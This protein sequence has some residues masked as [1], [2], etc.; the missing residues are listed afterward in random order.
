MPSSAG[1]AAP[2]YCWSGVRADEPEVQLVS[3]IHW[4]VPDDFWVLQRRS[5]CPRT[6][7][8]KIDGE[9]ATKGRRGDRFAAQYQRQAIESMKLHHRY[10]FT[11]PVALDLLFISRAKNPPAIYSAAKY[12]LDL[13][14]DVLPVNAEPRRRHVIYRDDRQVRFLYA[15][16]HQRWEP[17]TASE[18]GCTYI[19]ARPARDAIADLCAAYELSVAEE[20]RL[21]INMSDLDDDETSPF[22]V[23]ELPAH[24]D[25]DLD[26]GLPADATPWQ[27]WAQ[28]YSRFNAVS[29]MQEHLLAQHDGLHAHAL[30]SYLANRQSKYTDV[31]RDLLAH[32]RRTLLSSAMS[33]PMPG[34][35]RVPGA[36]VRFKSEVRAELESFRSQWPLLRKLVV[37]VKLTFLVISPV[38]GKDLDNLALTVLPIAHDVL[39]PHIEPHLLAP[40]QPYTQSP[41]RAEA[42]HRLRSLN[43]NSVC[44]YQVIELPRSLADHEGG[45]LRLALGRHSGV[46]W[47]DKA[48]DY[49]DALIKR[50][51]WS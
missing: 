20:D 3:Q 35:P 37:P 8:A 9:P 7:L 4:H 44:S 24:F 33:I 32:D 43:A 46:S 19:T 6:I 50:N 27:Q 12:L 28:D 49:I 16:M 17:G 11:G 38:Q 48:A 26:D 45:L 14:G 41:Y 29:T 30:A 5:R 36:M 2:I 34:L 25:N 21:D 13:L 23:P 10:P 31:F 39:K 18:R 22:A 47:W 42:L 40:D 51:D 15:D 1:G